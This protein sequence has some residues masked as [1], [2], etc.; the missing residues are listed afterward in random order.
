MAAQKLIRLFRFNRNLLV[1]I[2]GSDNQQRQLEVYSKGVQNIWD[3]V[4]WLS[5]H[6]L[7]AVFAGN[8]EAA[9]DPADWIEGKTYALYANYN[10]IYM[11][12]AAPVLG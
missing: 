7:R 8:P 3:L 5:L 4:D 12:G 11:Q 9:D 2:E 6:R 10:M 1:F